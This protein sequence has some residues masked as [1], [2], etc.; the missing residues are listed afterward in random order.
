LTVGAPFLLV[1]LAAPVDAGGSFARTKTDHKRTH[2]R[3][4]KKVPKKQRD[5]KRV[6]RRHRHHK[7]VAR[8]HVHRRRKEGRRV[9]RQEKDVRQVHRQGEIHRVAGGATTQTAEGQGKAAQRAP[10]GKGTL[11]LLSVEVD[12]ALVEKRA[13]DPDALEATRLARVVRQKAPG[14]YRRVQTRVLLGRRAN[15]RGILRGFAWLRKNMTPRDTALVFITIHG[16]YDDM[17]FFGM[18]PAGFKATDK[19][20][21]AVWAQEVREELLQTKG[22]KVVLVESCN[23]AAFLK[24]PVRLRPLAD[25]L[26]VCSCRLKES[27]GTRMG[28]ALSEALGGSAGHGQ[29]VTTQ[30]LVRYLRRQLRKYYKGSQHL[31]VLKAPSLKPFALVR[32]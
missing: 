15:R 12:C 28:Y 7:H 21:T 6:V 8:T 1:I 19:A 10:G 26:L 16:G 20:R 27:S 22:R 5:K 18:F 13:K 4:R 30:D 3:A 24:T 23:S 29:V 17:G 2:K 14:V 11:Y 31:A 32:R 9:H 25:T